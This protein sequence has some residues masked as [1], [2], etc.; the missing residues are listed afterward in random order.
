MSS[1]CQVLRICLQKTTNRQQVGASAP[2][3]AE[4][5]ISLDSSSECEE[6]EPKKVVEA[7]KEEQ[8]EG[9]AMVEKMAMWFSELILWL[10][11]KKRNPMSG[12]VGWR[13]ISKLPHPVK[14]EAPLKE[15]VS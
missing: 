15:G 4:I 5:G 2:I 9:K 1:N 14:K 7:A 11:P 3:P 10:V 13:V 6:A 8:R 12:D